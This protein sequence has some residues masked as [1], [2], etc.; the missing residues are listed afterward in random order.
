MKDMFVSCDDCGYADICKIE[1]EKRSDCKL[2]KEIEHQYWK[3]TRVIGQYSM[4][5]IRKMQGR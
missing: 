3:K 1:Q 5:D 4:T 2:H